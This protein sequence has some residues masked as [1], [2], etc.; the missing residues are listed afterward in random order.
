QVR[1]GYF[2]MGRVEKGFADLPTIVDR[3][4][5]INRSIGFHL[6][7][8]PVTMAKRWPDGWEQA[9]LPECV[10]VSPGELSQE[11]YAEA[12][13]GCHV[14]L[15][16]YHPDAYRYRTSAVFEEARSLGRIIVT[17]RQTWMASQIEC[18]EAAGVT[19]DYSSG[20]DAAANALLDATG[21]ASELLEK[22]WNIAEKRVGVSASERFVDRVLQLLGVASIGPNHSA[23][24]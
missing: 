8:S 11:E 7:V 14:I 16:N 15:L 3:T 17:P 24:E 23:A 2:G 10:Q 4:L 12:F 22:A 21:I 5:A 19:Y 1:V 18:G 6:Q 20:P 13:A 9:Q